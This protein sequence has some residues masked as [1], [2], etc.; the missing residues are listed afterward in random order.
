M[1]S[2][3]Y[4]CAYHLVGSGAMNASSAFLEGYMPFEDKYTKTGLKAVNVDLDGCESAIWT[5]QIVISTKDDVDQNTI[6]I[7]AAP[8][9]PATEQI[10]PDYECQNLR[11]AHD[12][13]YSAGHPL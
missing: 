2:S 4:A 3:A 5:T 10:W 8:A 11:P 1:S 6:D 13:P 9:P 12:E 7:D